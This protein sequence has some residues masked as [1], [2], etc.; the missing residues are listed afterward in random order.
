VTGSTVSQPFT[1]LTTVIGSLS[2]LFYKGEAS[3]G[4]EAIDLFEILS[5]AEILIYSGVLY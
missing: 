3:D 1:L 2:S 5:R 4:K